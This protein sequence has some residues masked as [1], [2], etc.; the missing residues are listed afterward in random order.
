M[1]LRGCDT[2]GLRYAISLSFGGMMRNRTGILV[3]ALAV[4]V[5]SCGGGATEEPTTA[6]PTGTDNSAT[7]TTTGA[8]STT[9]AAVAAAG[10]DGE[11]CELMSAQDTATETMDIFDP[12][13]VEAANKEALEAIR[14]ARDLV[15][16]EIRD[17]YDTLAAAFEGLVTALEE[18][19]WDMTAIDETDPRILRMA[20]AEVLAA[21]DAL[22]AY[23]GLDTGEGEAA[24]ISP[25]AES[26]SDSDL[27]DVL[28]APGAVLLREASS[29]INIFTSTASFDD[30]VSYFEGVLGE[31]PVNVSGAAG[32]RVAS[33]LSSTPVD[34]LVQVEEGGSE[35]LIYITLTG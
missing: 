2:N 15:P 19:G 26:G 13:S 8:A 25:G 34:V 10:G 21:A 12:A 5:V 35:L 31:A 22:I 4:V 28:V 17:E 11:F 6:P 9:T 29:G 32:E 1:L 23:C 7:T 16:G 20:S 14:R 24:V 27:P 30:T 18:S 33:F 3:I